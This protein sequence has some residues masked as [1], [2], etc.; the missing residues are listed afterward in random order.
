MF[1]INSLG[2]GIDAWVREQVSSGR[3]ESE[4]EVF[5]EA[6]RLF[7]ETMENA[8]VG[9]AVL[10]AQIQAGFDSGA[11]R[12]AEEVFTELLNRTKSKNAA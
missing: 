1:T 2:S 6:M 7:R 5:F 10:K 4:D 9:K 8:A 11:G 3:F 12:P